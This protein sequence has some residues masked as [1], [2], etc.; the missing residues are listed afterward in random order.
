MA[1][2]CLTLYGQESPG[3]ISLFELVTLTVCWSSVNSTWCLVT[4]KFDLCWSSV[5]M[6]YVDWS[7]MNLTFCWSSINVINWIV[8]F[9]SITVT[10]PHRTWCSSCPGQVSCPWPGSQTLWSK[11]PERKIR[12]YCCPNMRFNQTW[13]NTIYLHKQGLSRNYFSKKIA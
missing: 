10:C 4:Y 12:I 5:N 9:S 11:D 7:S 3:W 6:T 13:K 1:S 2:V 8:G